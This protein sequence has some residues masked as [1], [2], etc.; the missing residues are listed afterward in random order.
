MSTTS[1]GWL[2]QVT[3]ELFPPNDLYDFRVRETIDISKDDVREVTFSAKYVGRHSAG[4]VLHRFDDA[5]LAGTAYKFPL[6]IELSFFRGTVPVLSTP[7]G[8]TASWFIGR[9]GSGFDLFFFDVPRDLPVS[10]TIAVRI[11]VLTPNAEFA[12]AYGPVDFVIRKV[13][14]K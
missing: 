6:R 11:D 2:K 8:E 13:S 7:S 3:A 9:S 10:E 12:N 1:L 5:A 14:D 4:L